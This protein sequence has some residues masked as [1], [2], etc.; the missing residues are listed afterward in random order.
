MNERKKTNKNAY[1]TIIID[2]AYVIIMVPIYLLITFIR[3]F[4]CSNKHKIHKNLRW[5]SLYIYI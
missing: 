4:F 2:T 1:K 3:S 5:I